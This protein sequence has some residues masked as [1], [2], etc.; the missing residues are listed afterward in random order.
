MIVTGEGEVEGVYETEQVP[1]ERV[2]DAGENFPSPL[3]D[4]VIVPEGEL[5]VTVA[6]HTLGEPRFTGDGEQETEAAT[7]EVRLPKETEGMTP[8]GG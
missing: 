8:F 3:L 6:V 1:E 2:H 4:Q 5:P 7:A